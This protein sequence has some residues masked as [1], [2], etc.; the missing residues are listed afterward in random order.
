MLLFSLLEQL[1]PLLLP[2]PL[3]SLL[4]RIMSQ[5]NLQKQLLSLDL[6]MKGM[7]LEPGRL[8]L[9]QLN[10]MRGLDHLLRSGPLGL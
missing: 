3:P 8:P 6:E 4:A 5:L 10:Q 2:Q 7:K 1:K 9:S